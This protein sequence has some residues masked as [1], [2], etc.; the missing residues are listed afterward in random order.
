M[1]PNLVLLAVHLSRAYEIAK[2]GCHT[3]G[4]TGTTEGEEFEPVV[5]K[6]DVQMLRDF[7]GL[8]GYPE[9]PDII[10]EL[11]PYDPDTILGVL[12][13][14][15]SETLE[16]IKKRIDEFQLNSPE[17][18]DTL[19]SSCSALFKS[20]IR[21]LQLSFKDCTQILSVAK[22]IAGLSGSDKIQPEH[23]AEAI[24]YKCISLSKYLKNIL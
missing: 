7:Y 16:D 3:I 23:I 1:N 11:T 22:T 8:K 15:K 13:N 19:A 4:L 6:R 18:S 21:K 10:I 12:G 17:V 14:R 2:A 24:Q 5:D 9:D 20:A